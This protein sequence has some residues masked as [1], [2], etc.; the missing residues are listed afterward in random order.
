MADGGFTMWGGGTIKYSTFPKWLASMALGFGVKLSADSD[1][2]R[3]R[4]LW[5]SIVLEKKDVKVIRVEPVFSLPSVKIEHEKAGAPEVIRF[6]PQS[7]GRA[8]KLTLALKSLG[9]PVEV[10]GP[11]DDGF[12]SQLMRGAGHR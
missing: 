1:R 3:V 7:N 12:W 8:E 4:A 2:L 9:Y 6:S 10:A 11:A 5:H